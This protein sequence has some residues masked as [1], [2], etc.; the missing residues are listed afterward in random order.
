M[1]M[2]F[3]ITDRNRARMVSLTREMDE[4]VLRHNGRFYFA[5]DS[6]L[7]PSVAE[8]YLGRERLDRFFELKRRVDPELMIETDLWRRVLRPLY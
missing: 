2:D 8:V 4:I 1:A 6:S 7:R 3:R 5:K